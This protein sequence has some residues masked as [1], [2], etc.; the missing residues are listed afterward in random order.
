MLQC[1]F[2]RIEIATGKTNEKLQLN[3]Y[4]ETNFCIKFRSWSVAAE[5]FSL[6][7]GLRVLLFISDIHFLHREEIGVIAE[8]GYIDI[9]CDW[10][11]QEELDSFFFEIQCFPWTRW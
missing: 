4:R 5:L 9:P 6:D 3:G 1:S 8:W 7:N 10:P 11:F 2:S